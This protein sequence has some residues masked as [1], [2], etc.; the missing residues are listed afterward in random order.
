[1]K[2][3]VQ[4]ISLLSLRLIFSHVSYKTSQSLPQ[5]ASILTNVVSGSY[6]DSKTACVG[7]TIELIFPTLS[8]NQ[9]GLPRVA[10]SKR[11]DV[12]KILR[13]ME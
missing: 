1:M 8:K 2:C 3:D 5:S 6:R 10:K 12:H 7:A 4:L 11:S 13:L 9:R